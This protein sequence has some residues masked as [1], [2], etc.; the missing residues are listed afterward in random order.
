[1]A[2]IKE[3]KEVVVMGLALAKSIADCV[4]DGNFSSG[5]I[6]SLIKV[7]PKIAP[8]VKDASQIPSELGDLDAA[9]LDELLKCVSDEIGAD[10]AHKEYVEMAARGGLMLLQLVLELKKVKQA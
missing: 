6:F 2:G 9:E 10:Y 5:D 4:K 8:A 3:T 1:M 7:I